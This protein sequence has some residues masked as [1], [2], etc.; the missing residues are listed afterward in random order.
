MDLDT[1]GFLLG[2][3]FGLGILH[4]LIPD[5]HTWPITF[6]Y[7][8]GTTTGRGGIRSG[9]WFSLAFTAQRAMMSMIVFLALSAAIGLWGVNLATADAAVNGP[10][11]IVVGAAMAV[12]G[13]LI[14]TNRVGH[15]HPFMRFS[16][17]DYAKHTNPD[18]TP[19]VQDGRIPTHWC[20]IHGFISGFGTDSSILSTWVYFTTILFFLV[21][22]H[23]WYIGWLPGTLFGLGTFVV[24][25][26]IGFLFGEALQIA[27]RVGPN[28]IAQF[29]RLVGAR[30]LLL[31]GLTFVVFGPLY[32]T[33]WYSA[34][35]N[36]DAGQFIVI[37]V[38][39][40]LA[41][42]TMIFTWR[43]VKRKY[44]RDAPDPGAVGSVDGEAASGPL[45][46]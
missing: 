26:S 18:G 8:V 40:L 11:Y 1:L 38:L 36:L 22:N 33:G 21:P 43:E 13:Y 15:F 35:S 20:I 44:P 32:W 5:E 25:M 45:Q 41:V 29:G 4:G 12:A 37:V 24:L 23:L 16:Q 34:T 7:S 14:L 46:A 10:V 42:P 19:K 27:K 28:R 3:C 30:T 6:A 39:V 17:S 2:G 31:G 9:A